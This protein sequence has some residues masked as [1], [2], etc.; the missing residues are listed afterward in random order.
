M[1]DSEGLQS[2]MNRRVFS[3]RSVVKSAAGIIA[4]G[5]MGCG[6][7]CNSGSAKSVEAGEHPNLLFV[8]ADQMRAMAMSCS[9][10]ANLTTPNMDRLAAEAPIRG[11]L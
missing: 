4:G 11:R 8:Y 5:V 10:D 9:G 6:S 3:R 7:G 1:S 2:S